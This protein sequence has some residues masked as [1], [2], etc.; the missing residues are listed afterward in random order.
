MSSVN[1]DIDITRK[2]KMFINATA[3]EVLFG[4]AA[5]GGKSYGQTVDAFLCAIKYPGS[6]QLLLRRTFSELDKS[7]IRT[8]LAWYPRDIYRYNSSSHTIRFN[9]G[10]VLDF[11]YCAN[12]NDVFQYQSA[13]YDIIRFD[14]L[15]HFTKFQYI[16]LISRVRGSNGF[17][18][19]VKSSTNPGHVG[20]TWV[21][22]RFVDPA[23]PNTVF[24]GSDGMSRIFIPSLLTDN[25]F[26]MSN[27]PEYRKRLEALPEREKKALL[28]GDW[29]IFEGQYFEEFD[30]DL[31][32]CDPFP[33]PRE[34]RRYRAIDY[35]LDML[36]CYWIAVDS[37]RNWYVY[38][39]LCESNLPISSAADKINVNTDDDE[40]IYCTFAPPDLWNRSQ[41]TGRSKAFIFSDS[42]LSL[43]KSNN[44]REAGWLAIKEAMQK[45]ANGECR[46]HIFSTCT[47]LIKCLPALQRDKKK[48]TD[49]A[50]EPHEVTHSPDALRYFAIA[51][52]RPAP[53]TDRADRVKY[54]PDLLR[55][56]RRASSAEKK[57]IEE[58][59]GK[60]QL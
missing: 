21:K 55:D 10:S 40:D 32:V 38:R 48:P 31:H 50:T 58:R 34:W 42:G 13:E 1:V 30:R 35:G 33:M 12:E 57:M 25:T 19:Q 9:N 27:D 24:V 23:P 22:E 39:E 5:G 4:G 28:Y 59:Y 3:T 43:V 14:E 45:D 26:L 20:H 37:S 52:T 15:T 16:Y 44:D 17:P 56:Y 41:E 51:W 7:L 18:K 2:Q 60:P 46:L 11:G 49:A 53:E 8:V 47:E 6:K 54:S 36:A 29:N